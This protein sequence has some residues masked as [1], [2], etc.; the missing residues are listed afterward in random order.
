MVKLLKK[1]TIILALFLATS[2]YESMPESWD[3]GAKPR[4]L[5]GVRGFPPA[6]DDYGKG[7]KNGC[8]NI[9]SGVSK[10]WTDVL[11]SEIN[12]VMLSKN[13]NYSAGWFDGMEQCVYIT[14]WDVL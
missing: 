10:G 9:L 2:C 4:P 8:T 5:T 11:P 6:T 7:F 12:P 13:A 14:D 3:W 1:P